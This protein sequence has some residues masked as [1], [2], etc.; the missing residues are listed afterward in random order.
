MLS[1]K[2]FQFV[3]SELS[4]RK[5]NEGDIDESLRK[6]MFRSALCW[7][8]VFPFYH[9]SNWPG[10]PERI[11]DQII[12]KPNIEPEMKLNIDRVLNLSLRIA[13]SYT[14]EESLKFIAEEIICFV[15]YF[16]RIIT[17]LNEKGSFK[18]T[19]A[20][21]KF[22]GIPISFGNFDE[23]EYINSQIPAS[24]DRPREKLP[25]LA[26][27]NFIDSAIIEIDAK[28][29]FEFPFEAN[30]LSM[31]AEDIAAIVRNIAFNVEGVRFYPLKDRQKTEFVSIAPKQQK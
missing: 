6:S 9:E 23:I 16:N 10:S 4:N 11:G 7:G 24:S 12:Y 14:N 18:F 13:A 26:N 30:K 28:R 17:N 8:V 25:R 19:F 22:T 31:Y 1:S 15:N 2:L 21:E 5:I 20:L 27:W 29:N 3:N